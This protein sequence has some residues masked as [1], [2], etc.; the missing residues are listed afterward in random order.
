MRLTWRDWAMTAT[1]AANAIVVG[2]HAMAGRQPSAGACLLVALSAL[3]TQ[4]SWMAR[5]LDRRTED[6]GRRCAACAREGPSQGCDP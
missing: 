3:M 5:C 2:L 6:D 4:A 1:L